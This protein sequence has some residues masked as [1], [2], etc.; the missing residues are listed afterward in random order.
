MSEADRAVPTKGFVSGRDLDRREIALIELYQRQDSMSTQLWQH[1]LL[2]NVAVVAMIVLV[3]LKF[4]GPAGTAASVVQLKWL[5]SAAIAIVWVAFTIAG[6]D[7]IVKAQEILIRIGHQIEGEIGDKAM[8]F[9]KVSRPVN[10]IRLFHIVV[11]LGIF[12]LCM[13][14]VLE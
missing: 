6:L 7:A 9:A 8:L 1:F 5:L 12:V 13:L 3:T 10:Q 11:D 4:G 14:L 2:A